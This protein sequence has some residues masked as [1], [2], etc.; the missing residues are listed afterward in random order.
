MANYSDLPFSVTCTM[1]R[2]YDET[3]DFDGIRQLVCF[4][5]GTRERCVKC[6]TGKILGLH[7]NNTLTL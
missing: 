6:G 2:M 4:S 7:K 5:S 1:H 3:T